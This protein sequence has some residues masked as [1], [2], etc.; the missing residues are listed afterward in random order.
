[1]SGLVNSVDPNAYYTSPAPKKNSGLNM[2]TFL[3]LLTVQL[4]TQNPLEP[5][6]DSDMFAQISQLGQ[7]QGMQ[8]LQ[9]QGDFQKAQSLIGKVVDAVV[10]TGASS[11]SNIVTGAVTGVT[12]GADG[13]IKLNVTDSGGKDNLIGL[14]SIQ[15]VYDAP[16]TDTGPVPADYV[17]LIGKNVS[18]KNGTVDVAGEVT[19]IAT[20]DGVIMVDVK[21]SAGVK[22]QLPVGQITSIT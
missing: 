21:N 1:M 7:V 14:E 8:N 3:R 5:M 16:K 22:L 11:A 4:A 2:D 13:K 9:D 20:V 10:T 15:N 17:Y 19:G 12:I 18:G 6:K